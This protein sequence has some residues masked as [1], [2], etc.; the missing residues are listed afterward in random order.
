MQL[1]TNKEA[2][3]MPYS[4]YLEFYRPHELTDI[5]LH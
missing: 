5:L 1:P 3:I 4:P 2:L